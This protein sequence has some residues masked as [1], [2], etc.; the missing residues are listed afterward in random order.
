[1]N[2]KPSNKLFLTLL[3]GS[4][5]LA[6]SGMV[7]AGQESTNSPAKTLSGALQAE[8]KSLEASGSQL[9]DAI[10]TELDKSLKSL[11]ASS[12]AQSEKIE[13]ATNRVSSQIES[14]I[15]QLAL[16]LI[17]QVSEN[18]AGSELSKALLEDMR[19]FAASKNINAE[20][21]KQMNDVQ[22]TAFLKS[23]SQDRISKAI[24]T[25][26]ELAE[27]KSDSL[28]SNIL[29]SLDSAVAQIREKAE[30]AR[31]EY[32]AQIESSLRD[33]T[34]GLLKQIS[35]ETDKKI[36]TKTTQDS[37][38]ASVQDSVQNLVDSKAA[39]QAKLTK[40]ESEL[41]GRIENIKLFA[42][43]VSQIVSRTDETLP[44]T[45]LNEVLR[46]LEDLRDNLILTNKQKNPEF[47]DFLAELKLRKNDE[48][49][50]MAQDILGAAADRQILPSESIEILKQ[51]NRK[52]KAY[53]ER[54]EAQAEESTEVLQGFPQ[55][56]SL[57]VSNSTQPILDDSSKTVAHSRSRALSTL[58]ADLDLIK[59]SILDS[60]TK[61][62][63]QGKSESLSTAE[64]RIQQ[65]QDKLT[66]AKLQLEIAK[67]NL[68]KT[69]QEAQRQ[70]NDT[71]RKAQK[72]A[73]ATNAQLNQIIKDAITESGV[74]TKK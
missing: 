42:A 59:S 44:I 46:K 74:P 72:E 70:L 16:S 13:E 50:R 12:L 32:Q 51:M 64:S 68:S 33:A 20:T 27:G 38:Q 56:L 57:Y 14:Q 62:A 22:F 17:N 66:K 58:S 21:I 35:D 71:L 61:I 9:I 69:S 34:R 37:V 7:S 28:Q 49:F 53:Q 10:S 3:A 24:A 18:V 52:A 60:A 29:Q 39:I 26:K 30:L 4:S 47:S 36:I 5:I 15:D 6:Q 11:S 65:A 31:V 25:S 73:A 48:G 19:L 8:A 2:S 63:S 45:N 54:L 55:A 67:S 43:D 40:I 23:Y 41:N 1:M